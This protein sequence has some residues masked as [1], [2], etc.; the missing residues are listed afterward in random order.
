MNFFLPSRFF[1]IP[2]LFFAVNFFTAKN[3]LSWDRKGYAKDTL[4]TNKLFL[5]QKI[6]R[7]G[8]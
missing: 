6:H 2:P 5:F 7:G 8:W 1:A 4:Q 3:T